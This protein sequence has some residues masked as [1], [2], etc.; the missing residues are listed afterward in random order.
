VTNFGDLVQ[1]FDSKSSSGVSASLRAVLA[2][3]EKRKSHMETLRES[4]SVSPP[5]V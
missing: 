3:S 4:L 5:W 2:L 1:G